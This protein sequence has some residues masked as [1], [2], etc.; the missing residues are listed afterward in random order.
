V[1][2][3]ALIPDKLF[4]LAS[5]NSGHVWEGGFYI[6]G[7]KI[8]NGLPKAIKDISIKLKK[9]KIALKHILRTHAFYSSD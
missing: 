7:I 5:G 3:I 1:Y 6:Q 8:F 4:T 2:I 9:F